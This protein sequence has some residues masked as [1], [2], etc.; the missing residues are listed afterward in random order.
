MRGGKEG[1]KIAISLLRD[2][3]AQTVNITLPKMPP[4]PPMPPGPPRVAMPFDGVDGD[5]LFAEDLAGAE[6]AFSIMTLGDAKVPKSFEI[7]I[8]DTEIGESH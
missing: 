7:E 6:N 1:D 5:S 2:R 4:M 8:M 3:K